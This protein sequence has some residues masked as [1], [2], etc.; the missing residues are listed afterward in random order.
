MK[1]PKTE[2]IPR[3]Y[4]TQKDDFYSKSSS[5]GHAGVHFGVKGWSPKID[6][7]CFE[8]PENQ[9]VSLGNK[10]CKKINFSEYRLYMA[11]QGC[12][13]VLRVGAQK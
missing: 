5:H 13:S 9:R 7:D 8:E 1:S 10:I 12:I 3:R 2:K 11:M 6:M 4:N